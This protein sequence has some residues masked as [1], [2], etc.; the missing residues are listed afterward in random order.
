M[1]TQKFEKIYIFN[2][3]NKSLMK[4]VIAIFNFISSWS[5]NLDI[6]LGY[7]KKY[8]IKIIK[9]ENLLDET[10]YVF[11]DML[12]FINKITNNNN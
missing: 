3:I 2:F 12:K 11:K 4:M 6:N 10:F 8:L 5:T 7:K 9:Y 1:D